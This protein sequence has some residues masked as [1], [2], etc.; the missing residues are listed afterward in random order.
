MCSAYICSC[1]DYIV[2][3]R[4]KLKM[5]TKINS[6]DSNSVIRF[7]YYELEKVYIHVSV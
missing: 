6:V 5:N 4:V 1:M 3:R 2:H 7:L